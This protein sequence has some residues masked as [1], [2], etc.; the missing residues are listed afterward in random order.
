M[1]ICGFFVVSLSLA[2]HH[3][4]TA[5]SYRLANLAL[6]GFFTLLCLA[7][8]VGS[9]YILRG[10]RWASILVGIVALL[11][12]TVSLMGMFA[13]FN[14]APYSVVGVA[15]DAFAIISVGVFWFS[16]RHASACHGSS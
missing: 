10:A 12:V 14:S 6:L 5:T 9:L 2:A 15:F 7:G 4:V 13:F 16:R 8:V 11:T 3:A 1:A